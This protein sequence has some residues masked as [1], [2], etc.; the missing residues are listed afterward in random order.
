MEEGKFCVIWLKDEEKSVL[1]VLEEF[2]LDMQAEHML[3]WHYI[4]KAV[5]SVYNPELP[6]VQRRLVPEWA[7]R[8]TQQRSPSKPPANQ[9][10]KYY[11]VNT[12]P[13]TSRLFVVCGGW[14]VL[15]GATRAQV[16]RYGSRMP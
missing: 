13:G 12:I 4:H 16:A 11:T 1:R 15:H 5:S 2:E 8:R 9:V 7:H 3:G 10:H 14:Q 6:L